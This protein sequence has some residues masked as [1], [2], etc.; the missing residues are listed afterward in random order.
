MPRIVAALI[1]SAGA[2]ILVNVG[3]TTHTWYTWP[4]FCLG[5][6]NGVAIAYALWADFGRK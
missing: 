1:S 2:F 6:F 5:I 3:M 4:A